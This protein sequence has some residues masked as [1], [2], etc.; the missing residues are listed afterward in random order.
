MSSV[1]ALDSDVN[2]NELKYDSELQEVDEQIDNDND[3]IAE[4]TN[5]DHIDLLA[6]TKLLDFN[7]VADFAMS[8]ISLLYKD[9]SVFDTEFTNHNIFQKINDFFKNNSS[10]ITSEF[11][12]KYKSTNPIDDILWGISKIYNK[13]EQYPLSINIISELGLFKLILNL[14]TKNDIDIFEEHYEAVMRKS[15]YEHIYTIAGLDDNSAELL[16][17]AGIVDKIGLK[18]NELVE[19]DNNN[20]NN[21]NNNHLSLYRSIFTNI[22]CLTENKKIAQ[23]LLKYNMDKNIL[24]LYSNLNEKTT[25]K[26]MIGGIVENIINHKLCTMN[27][28]HILLEILKCDD[29]DWIQDYDDRTNY[30]AFITGSCRPLLKILNDEE[31]LNSNSKTDIINA[32]VQ[33]YELNNTLN[34]LLVILLKRET[35]DTEL[36]EKISKIESIHASDYDSECDVINDTYITDEPYDLYMKIL[37]LEKSK[38]SSGAKNSEKI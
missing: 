34:T 8:I 10:L 35:T 33:N 22:L 2:N 13:K 25:A 18:F 3:E 12:R 20:N 17:D 14:Y 37:E 31:F 27:I 21:N 7:N 36:K 29:I 4:K 38:N 26:Y 19:T 1:S 28:F 5:G 30:P 32:I 15:I 6:N 11:I 16:I 9:S 23:I 24:I